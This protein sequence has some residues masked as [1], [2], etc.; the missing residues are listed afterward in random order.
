MSKADLILLVEDSPTQ[1]AH[2]QFILEDAGYRVT[3]A[4]DGRAGLESVR[5]EQ[6]LLVVTDLHMPEMN[7]LELVEHLRREFTSLPVILTTAAGTEAIAAEALHKGAASYVP[8]SH[9]ETM[10]AETVQRILGLARADR[11]AQKLVECQTSSHLAFSLYNDDSLVPAVI[12]RAFIAGHVRAP[13][14]RVRRMRKRP[15]RC[16][17][18]GAPMTPGRRLSIR[19]ASSTLTTGD[20]R[21]ACDGV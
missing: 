4:V 16:A 19:F 9:A 6:P 18:Y 10:L 13:W 2:M 3:V 21:I 20:G 8:K 14:S 7:G 11:M 5:A 17:W 15:F 12:A 1:A